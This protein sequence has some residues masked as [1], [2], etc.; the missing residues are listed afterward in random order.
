MED[1]P[2]IRWSDRQSAAVLAALEIPLRRRFRP[3]RAAAVRRSAPHASTGSLRWRRAHARPDPDVVPA[4]LGAQGSRAAA[5]PDVVPA[6]RRVRVRS[7]HLTSYMPATVDG[8]L[9]LGAF[10]GLCEA[11][12]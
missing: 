4:W 3:T 6:W 7:P 2:P 1:C 10:V 9:E 11:G 12:T 8:L 5:T